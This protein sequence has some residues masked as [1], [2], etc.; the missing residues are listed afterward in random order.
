M[1]PSHWF[2]QVRKSTSLF[3]D[4]KFALHCVVIVC[5]VQCY[6]SKLLKY[7]FQMAV[8]SLKLLFS[9]QNNFCHSIKWCLISTW[10]KIKI[11]KL[12]PL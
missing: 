4:D 9:I 6:S 5:L 7:L 12:I 11:G 3:H 8:F 2:G 10:P 1:V